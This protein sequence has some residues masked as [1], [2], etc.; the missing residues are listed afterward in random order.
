MNLTPR[1]R[2]V[3]VL[4]EQG[5]TFAQIGRELGISGETAKRHMTDVRGRLGLAGI[6]GRAFVA[7]VATLTTAAPKSHDNRR[8]PAA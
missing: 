7:R 6:P 5:K 4:Y 2:E 1:Q 3:L 8:R